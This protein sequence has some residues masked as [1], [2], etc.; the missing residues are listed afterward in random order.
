MLTVDVF[1]T[2]SV[3][4]RYIRDTPLRTSVGSK[5]PRVA[6]ETGVV[7]DAI[8]VRMTVSSRPYSSFQFARLALLTVPTT[9]TAE[10]TTV[11]STG[12]VMDTDGGGPVLPVTVTVTSSLTVNC[13]S[14]AVRRNTYVPACVNAT[15][16]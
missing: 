1:P 13:V 2:V 14:V 10:V 3:P 12:D 16:I 4:V 6:A 9:L 8:N 5:V 15:V 7:P 11:P